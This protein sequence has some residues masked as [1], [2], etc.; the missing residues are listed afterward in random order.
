VIIVDRALAQREQNNN[1]VR[2][3]LFGA[4][5][6]GKSVALQL[7]TGAAGMRLV[8]IVNRTLDKARVAC[9]YAGGLNPASV[10]DV[11]AFRRTVASGGCAITDD[12]ELVWASDCVDVVIEATGH[13]EYGAQVA[14]HALRTGKHVV[15]M[16]AE[17]DASIGPILNTYAQRAGLVYTYT[18][19][20]EPG[21]GMNLLRFAASVGFKPVLMGQM[22]GFLDR[23]RTPETQRGFADKHGQNPIVMSAFADGSK[24]AL[25]AAIMGNATG[26]Q[27]KVRGMRGYPC[28]H[29]QDMTSLLTEADFADGGLVEYSL[30]AAP[31]T[32]AFVICTAGHPEKRKLLA[33]LKMG[34]GPLYM[35]YTPYHL[36]PTQVQ[37]SVARAALFNDPTISPTGTPTCDTVACAKRD[38]RAG[39]ILDGVGGFTCYGLVEKYR[40]CEQHRFLPIGISLDCRLKR[41]IA[42]DQPL[43]YDDVELPAGRLCDQLR[44]EQREHFAGV[45]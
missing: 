30:G 28:A 38:L 37:H 8:A 39:E 3:A 12:P 22:K 27:P 1:P 40:I 16:G 35:F 10:A 13:V 41:D 31:H 43:T 19:G 2:V 17:T 34:D 4:G 45:K 25:E 36:P 44:R 5:F 42:K 29:V 33:Y 26:F 11:A 20:D 14:F 7:A 23:Y 6:T 32:G 21:V 24:L 9:D 15:M 18:D